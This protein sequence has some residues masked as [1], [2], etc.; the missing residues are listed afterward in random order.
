[1]KRRVAIT[2]LADRHADP[3][4]RRFAETR[5]VEVDDTAMDLVLTRAWI[6]ADFDDDNAR[7][8]IVVDEPHDA[9]END[10]NPHEPT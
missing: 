8:I 1:M 5:E 2:R 9:D 7:I 10:P 6:A 4:E 3:H